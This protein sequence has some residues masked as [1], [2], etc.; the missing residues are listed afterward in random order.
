VKIR[1]A[2]V[3]VLAGALTLAACAPR[4]H[5]APG[6][7]PPPGIEAAPGGLKF[8]VTVKPARFKPGDRV[9]LEATLFNDSRER[10]ERK[11]PTSCTWDY[12]IAAMDGHVLGPVRTCKSGPD[13]L[14]LEPGELRMILRNWSGRERYFAAREPLKPGTYQ[15]T[16]GFIDE[17][18]RVVPMA[19]PVTI[20]ILAR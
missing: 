11:F 12:E 14:R 17:H 7:A 8:A 3:V 1:F 4:G 10:F 15:V 2:H 20:E 13:T 9:V 16:A 18:R 6:P 5:R 19:D